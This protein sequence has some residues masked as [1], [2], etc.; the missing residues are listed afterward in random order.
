MGIFGSIFKD[1]TLG[2]VKG[3]FEGVGSLAKDLRSAITGE[4]SPEKKAEIE[5]KLLELE[6]LSQQGQMEVSKQEAAHPS[7]FVSGGRPAVIWVCAISIGTYYIPQYVMA[8]ILWTKACWIAS[9]LLPYPIPE[10]EGIIALVSALL[11]LGALRTIEKF[12]GVARN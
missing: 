10:P 8:A 4:I 3:V 11:G 5:G 1:I 12:K 2:G 7:V 9:T 6:S